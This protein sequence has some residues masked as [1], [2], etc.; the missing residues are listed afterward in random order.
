MKRPT[1]EASDSYQA[2]T[3][4]RPQGCRG[5]SGNPARGRASTT[6]TRW[7]A[8]RVEYCAPVVIVE[9]GGGVVA[10][11]LSAVRDGAAAARW[12]WRRRGGGGEAAST[13]TIAKKAVHRWWAAV[14]WMMADRGGGKKYV[15]FFFAK[16]FFC[17]GIAGNLFF[18]PAICP[19]LPPKQITNKKI[20]ADLPAGKKPRFVQYGT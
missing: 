13:A 2:C 5:S 11:F 1:A 8:Q 3:P 19:W 16:R 12:H 15:W 7:R 9:G 18:L 20:R 10:A 4:S 17:P 6:P 14:V